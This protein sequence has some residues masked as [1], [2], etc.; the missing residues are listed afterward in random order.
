MKERQKIS[1]LVYEL[2]EAC[3]QNCRFCYNHWRPDGSHPVDRKLTARTLNRILKQAEVGSIS[4]SGGEPTLLSN[5]HDLALKCRLKGA[6]VNVLTNGT[7]ISEEDMRNFA[8]I[9]LGA[10]QIPLLSSDPAVHE[11]LTGLPGSWQRAVSSMRSAISILDTRHVAAVLIVTAANAGTIRSTLELYKELG[12]TSVMVNRFNYGGN[13]L[14]HMEELS[15]SPDGLRKA[16]KEVSDFAAA[17]PSIRFVSGVCTPL[18]LLDPADFPGI[19]FTSCSTELDNRPLTI[20]YRG[21]VRFCNHSPFVMG[22]I[23]ERSLK[24]ILEDET[25]RQRYSGIPEKCVSCKL[26]E[27]CKGGCRA[28]SEQVYGTFNAVDPILGGD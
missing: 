11:H 5:I 12:V 20:S 7:L 25:V 26:Y 10:L 28:A 18:C 16:F 8:S 27:R 21:D 9:G 14:K 4:F 2:T 19:K 22:N 24:D 3:N 15:L 13:G 6:N 17:N 1:F 23:W